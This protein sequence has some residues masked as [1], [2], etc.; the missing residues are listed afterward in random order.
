MRGPLLLFALLLATLGACSGSRE[1]QEGRAY[2]AYS[3]PGGLLNHQARL[4]RRCDAWSKVIDLAAFV[5]P[6]PGQGA[7]GISSPLQVFVLGRENPVSLNLPATLDCRYALMLGAFVEGP[8]QDLAEEHLDS[9]VVALGH[10]ASYACRTRNSQRGAKISQH[11]KG[12]AY[13]LHSVYLADGRVV[14]VKEGWDGDSDESDFWQELHAAACGPFNTV[15]GPESDR[16]HAD[17]L[18]FD[19][20]EER[21]G[22]TPYC[23]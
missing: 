5:Q 23:R 15:L 7:C 18:H 14:T 6:V 17:H 3:N 13:D 22:K 16:F 21:S 20:V 19:V 9:Q 4:P 11:A 12:L 1:V 8:M 2:E 10:G